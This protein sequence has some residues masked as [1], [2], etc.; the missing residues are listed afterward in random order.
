MVAS[1]ASLTGHGV[2]L[3]HWAQQDVL[4]GEG[5]SCELARA[6]LAVAV[7]V[8]L[9]FLGCRVSNTYDVL[10]RHTRQGRHT[11]TV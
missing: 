1:F 9:L 2:Q 7:S 8:T 11:I 5:G 3:G 10:Q 6:V 4:R